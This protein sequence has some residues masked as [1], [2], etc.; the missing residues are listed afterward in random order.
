MHARFN[1]RHDKSSSEFKL[2]VVY[3]SNR[4]GR[5]ASCSHGRAAAMGVAVE[6]SALALPGLGWWPWKVLEEVTVLLG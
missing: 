2:T 5:N 4:D 1:S 6:P 3:F